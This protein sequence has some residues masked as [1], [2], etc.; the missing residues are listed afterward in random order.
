MQVD[1]DQIY[2]P[3]RLAAL[4]DY[5]S[6]ELFDS[7]TE[8]SSLRGCVR[9][10]L[11]PDS[12]CYEYP[13]FSAQLAVTEKK[14][15]PAIW[16]W[17]HTPGTT[18]Y[19]LAADVTAI[20]P[21]SAIGLLFANTTGDD[22]YAFV[23]DPL[24]M[25]WWI[26][27]RMPEGEVTT[28]IAPQTLPIASAEPIQRLEVRV[29]DGEPEFLLNGASL[30]QPGELAGLTIPSR[31]NAGIIVIRSEDAPVGPVAATFDSFGIYALNG[32][33]ERPPALADV[34]PE[35]RVFGP[36]WRTVGEGGRSKEE[37]TATFPDV[38]DA[39]LRFDAWGW[40]ENAY[41][42]YVEADSG[43]TLAVSVHEFRD[44]Q[45]AA[46]A[47]QYLADERASLL[48]LEPVPDQEHGKIVRAL[49][50]EIA[51]KQE[52]SFF[53][54]D[55]TSVIRLTATSDDDS[56]LLITQRAAYSVGRSTG[57]GGARIA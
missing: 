24:R 55:G 30:A 40:R 17:D 53:L 38:E 15:E 33:V 19:A 43:A 22:G 29:T 2:A 26:D 18:S 36:A 4:D 25:I 23:V 41:R 14:P 47:L 54:L 16:R 48:G 21:T 37:I 31:G 6:V 34:L 27:E 50:G 28:V 1:P 45:A 5:A 13:H 57:L 7:M 12:W 52:A 3:A 51:G 11:E 9:E 49:T 42:E 35:A 10:A 44:E 56:S 20:A 39:A 32:G 46:Q 8:F